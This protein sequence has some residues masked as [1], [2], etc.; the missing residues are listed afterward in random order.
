MGAPPS[1]PASDFANEK[2]KLLR[3]TL[4]ERLA[5][6]AAR[7]GRETTQAI[8]VL[9]GVALN[10]EPLPAQLTYPL[11]PIRGWPRVV[12]GPASSINVYAT[13]APVRSFRHTAAEAALAAYGLCL[14]VDDPS[15]D[16]AL[17]LGTSRSQ[18]EVI[19]RRRRT[20]LDH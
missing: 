9:I 12:L 1:R 11:R 17:A 6:Y 19:R 7:T 3:G 8:R 13:F 20:V 15:L 18:A 2:R 4:S 5:N 10:A 16:P 14:C